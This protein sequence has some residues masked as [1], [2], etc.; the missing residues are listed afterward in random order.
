[1]EK[2]DLVPNDEIINFRIMISIFILEFQFNNQW[3]IDKLKHDFF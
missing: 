2:N 3:T 1:M